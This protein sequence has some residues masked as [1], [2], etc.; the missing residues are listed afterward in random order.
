MEGQNGG[1]DSENELLKDPFSAGKRK[2]FTP[3]KVE[4]EHS[5]KKTHPE[6]E[7]PEAK[8]RIFIQG[9]QK[10]AA[11]LAISG[12]E[13]E[14]TTDQVKED[15]IYL[16][17]HPK[18]GF[19][20][21]LRQESIEVVENKPSIDKTVIEIKEESENFETIVRIEDFVETEGKVD[22]DVKLDGK[23]ENVLSND[24]ESEEN[25]VPVG[26]LRGDNRIPIN[27]RRS[28]DVEEILRIC[29]G[30]KSSEYQRIKN[31]PYRVTE[32]ATL[33]CDQREVKLR[34][35]YDMDADDTPGAFTRNDNVRFYQIKR[36][37]GKLR[38]S[39]EVHVVKDKEGRVIDGSYNVRTGRDYALKKA[40][41]AETFAIVRRRGVHKASKEKGETLTRY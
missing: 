7:S 9:K 6:Q 5:R 32:T 39:S 24:E 10:F 11:V 22:I 40:C 2:D 8:R 33:L 26:W 18:Q 41:L 28:L 12:D 25:D 4:S 29:L 31:K 15:I 19:K 3:R 17:E 35:P 1:S 13:D 20:T 34:H 27:S 23:N 30:G 21:E 36:E 14:N 37:N 16:P 38:K